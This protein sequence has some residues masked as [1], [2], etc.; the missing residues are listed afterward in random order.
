MADSD[1]PESF[2]NLNREV[3]EGEEEEEEELEEPS[4][5]SETVCGFSI[6]IDCDAMSVYTGLPA[7]SFVWSRNYC[8]TSCSHRC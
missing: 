2:P 1:S 6:V 5:V 8:S 3:K 4:E 7:S